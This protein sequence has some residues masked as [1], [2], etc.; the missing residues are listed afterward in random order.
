MNTF[1]KSFLI[2]CSIIL[3]GGSS[4]EKLNIFF[5]ED[6]ETC[7][8]D[9]LGNCK[10]DRDQVLD[11]NPNPDNLLIVPDELAPYVDLV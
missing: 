10:T 8:K 3:I 1:Q 9:E 7:S 4:S 11:E 5:D 2:L 6:E